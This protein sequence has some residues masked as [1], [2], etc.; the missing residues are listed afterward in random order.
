MVSTRT[1]KDFRKVRNGKRNARHSC[2]INMTD[3]FI[4]SQKTI[5]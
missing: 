1:V 2:F 4:K 3:H 5:V